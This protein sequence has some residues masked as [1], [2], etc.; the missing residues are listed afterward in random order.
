MRLRVKPHIFAE[1][2]RKEKYVIVDTSLA[3]DSTIGTGTPAEGRRS[4]MGYGTRFHKFYPP[5][6]GFSASSFR[7]DP[8]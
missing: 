1:A 8:F 7:Y 5:P 4:V 6:G 2:A 3:H